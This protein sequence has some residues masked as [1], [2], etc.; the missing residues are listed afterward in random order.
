MPQIT[1]FPLFPFS[2]FSYDGSSYPNDAPGGVDEAPLRRGRSPHTRYSY[3][4]KQTPGRLFQRTASFGSAD[5]KS[6]LPRF[7][8]GGGGVGGVVSGRDNSA[9]SSGHSSGQSTTSS[10]GYGGAAKMTDFNMIRGHSPHFSPS[11]SNGKQR[12]RG[13]KIYRL[14][15]IALFSGQ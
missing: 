5:L 12:E 11:R 8:T 4:N 13:D 10:S 2:R 1:N 14:T 15:L 3:N 7:I 9:S 6:K